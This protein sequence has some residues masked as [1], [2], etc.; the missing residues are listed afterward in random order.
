MDSGRSFSSPAD[1]RPSPRQLEIDQFREKTAKFTPWPERP[2]W[3]PGVKK[4]TFWKVPQTTPDG[5]KRYSKVLPW[6]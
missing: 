3:V 4:S 2:W 6:S 5:Q 1:P